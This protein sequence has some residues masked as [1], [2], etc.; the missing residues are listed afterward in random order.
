MKIEISNDDKIIVKNVVDRVKNYIK[1][2]T[3]MIFFSSY[4]HCIVYILL[5]LLLLLSIG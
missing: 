2:C 4:C 5:S 3:G 1:Y